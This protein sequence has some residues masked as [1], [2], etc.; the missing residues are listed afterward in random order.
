MSKKLISIFVIVFVSLSLMVGCGT[1][2]EN[3]SDTQLQSLSV[4]PAS[5]AMNVGESAALT[6]LFSPSEAQNSRVNWISSNG[7]VVQV[8]TKGNVTAVGK[9]NCTVTVSSTENSKIFCDVAIV[10]NDSDEVSGTASAD[11]YVTMYVI[12]C[13]TSITLRSD[14]YPGAPEILQIPF[15]A[16]VSFISNAENGFCKVV[17]NSHT[18]YALSSYLGYEKQSTPAPAPS[19]YDKSSKDT[20]DTM[21]VVN[22]KQSITLRK[23]DSTS[24]GE[25]C[26]IPL[27]SA[28][29]YLGKANNGFYK[30]IYN[31]HTGYALA[32]YLTY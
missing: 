22:C 10:V 5:L 16:A 19:G 29:S 20:Y 1:G 13:H 8:D 11:Q 3:S 6:L 18:G 26:Q 4:N 21:F 2:S 23:S 32:S 17:Y 7:S 9:G 24:A 31:G 30:I 28:V 15:G 12:N 14:D 25:I 27:G